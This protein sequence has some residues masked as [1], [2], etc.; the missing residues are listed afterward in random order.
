M[1]VYFIR[2]L[3]QVCWEL[4]FGLQPSLVEGWDLWGTCAG[5][6]RYVLSHP[7]LITTEAFETGHDIVICYCADIS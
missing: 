1:L 6:A 4:V 3:K 5:W 2:S 7:P